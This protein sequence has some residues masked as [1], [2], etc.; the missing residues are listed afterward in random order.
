MDEELARRRAHKNNILRCRKL[1]E[2]KLMEHE[3]QYI[4]RR[5]SEERSALKAL[6]TSHLLGQL[7]PLG[8]DRA[9]DLSSLG[10]FRA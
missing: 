4:L 8:P 9:R 6:N 7:K 3:R 10:G 2:T 1:L 5:L